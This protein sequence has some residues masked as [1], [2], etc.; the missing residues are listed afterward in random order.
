MPQAFCLVT[1]GCCSHARL[2]RFKVWHEHGPQPY[3]TLFN[4][5]TV[6]LTMFLRANAPTRTHLLFFWSCACTALLSN[7][8]IF[9]TLFLVAS[10]PLECF[11]IAMKPSLRTSLGGSFAFDLQ[12]A[13]QSVGFR[14]SPVFLLGKFSLGM[15]NTSVVCRM[16][17]QASY[18]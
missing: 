4:S 7:T 16:L 18:L 10:F 15:A 2:A 5:K 8:R 14:T 11:D 13:H 6:S 1:Q 17:R 12:V 3:V 9:P